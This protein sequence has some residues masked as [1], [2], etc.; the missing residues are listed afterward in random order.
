MDAIVC[1]SLTRDFGALRAVDAL[2]FTVPAGNIF[3]LLGANGAGKT[4]T[5]HLLL[6]LLAPSSGSATV[7]GFDVRRD[8]EKIRARCGVLL[9]HHGLYERLSAETNLELYARIAGLDAAPRQSRI[10]EV[11][12]HFGLW[13]RRRERV[14][15]FSRGMKQKL[16]I[17]RAT[18]H[19]PPLIF[20][21]EPT[22]GLDPEAVVNL[23]HDIAALAREGS[24]VL[25]NTHNL[26]DA[27]KLS[28][29]VG[30]MR[31]GKLLAIGKPAELRA[32]STTTVTITGGG[33][34]QPHADMIASREGIASAALEAGILTIRIIG[35]Q[36]VAPIVRTLVEQGVDIEEV[37]RES[38]ALEDI[39]LE[40]VRE[41]DR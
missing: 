36:S 28:D 30:V 11:L 13:N 8:A 22:A 17:A 3:T 21:D 1:D 24:T 32:R 26:T 34:L 39:F 31:Q 19:R 41:R 14:A 18:L 9:E 38:A 10:R 27:E 12:E 5:I 33:L 23:R 15:T 37:R 35:E 4:T 16:A 2:S 29:L 40:L 7:L 6:G 25:L 20:L